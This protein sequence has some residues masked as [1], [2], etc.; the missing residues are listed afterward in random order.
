MCLT[1]LTNNDKHNDS[2]I[3]SPKGPPSSDNHSET[4]EGEHKNNFS[5]VLK[6]TQYSCVGFSFFFYFQDIVNVFVC[7]SGSQRNKDNERKTSSSS[8]AEGPPSSDDHSETRE[9]EKY[10]D[11]EESFPKESDV[12]SE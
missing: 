4:S 1:E 2:R 11:A 9:E 7:V 3:S 12:Q 5:I 6:I 8:V 10:E